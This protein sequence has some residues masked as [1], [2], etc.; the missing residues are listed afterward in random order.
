VSSVAIHLFCTSRLVTRGRSIRAVCVISG[1]KPLGFLPDRRLSQVVLLVLQQYQGLRG[2]GQDEDPVVRGFDH[3]PS[4][5][6]LE[7][8]VLQ[9]N[10]KPV[11]LLYERVDDD[12][13]GP[14]LPAAPEDG[15]HLAGREIDLGNLKVVIDGWRAIRT[16]LWRAS[17]MPQ[18]QL[19][20]FLFRSYSMET[21]L[22][23]VTAS[24]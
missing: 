8:P 23:D 20:P 10:K 17:S 9:V 14:V 21:S 16:R 3:T 11:I 5:A 15:E 1:L 24:T 13:K 22:G 19:L 4:G 18:P 2:S 12:A 6:A 7:D